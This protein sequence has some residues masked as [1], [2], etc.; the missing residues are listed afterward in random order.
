MVKET[1]RMNETKRF[2]EELLK[3]KREKMGL[4]QIE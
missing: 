3:L 4:K 1:R 2:K